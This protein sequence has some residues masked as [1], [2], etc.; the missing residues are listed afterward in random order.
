MRVAAVRYARIGISV[1]G[2]LTKLKAFQFSSSANISDTRGI[3][4]AGAC[5]ASITCPFMHHAVSRITR[6]V[7]AYATCMG[8]TQQ[9]VNLGAWAGSGGR[10]AASWLGQR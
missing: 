5:F 3:P 4:R 6:Y 8:K 2:R 10:V 7:M 1:V 9:N